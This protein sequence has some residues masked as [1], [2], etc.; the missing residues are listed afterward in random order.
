MTN[1]AVVPT[2]LALY[3]KHAKLYRA[4]IKEKGLTVSP[5][6]IKEEIKKRCDAEKL[7]SYLEKEVAPKDES[8]A[9][10]KKKAQPKKKVAEKKKAEPKKKPTAKKSPPKKKQPSFQSLGITSVRK[11]QLLMQPEVIS[12]LS[13]GFRFDLGSIQALQKNIE[14]VGEVYEPI[15]LQ[16]KESTLDIVKGKRRVE[17]IRRIVKKGGKLAPVPVMLVDEATSLKMGTSLYI[18]KPLNPL[19][20]A[21]VLYYNKEKVPANILATLTGLTNKLVKDRIA[22]VDACKSVKTALLKDE[23]TDEQ[24]ASIVRQHP[25]DLKAQNTAFVELVGR[26]VA[27]KV[28]EVPQPKKVLR[29]AL[30]VD[31]GLLSPT[32]ARNL[33]STIASAYTAFR[34]SE[35]SPS[36]SN[37]SWL[38][39]LDLLI[40]IRNL[41]ASGKIPIK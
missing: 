38:D 10:P 19:E 9:L 40:K 32:R 25:D 16:L 37:E 41:K 7:E 12:N 33:L 21:G 2:G 18:R 31:D 20:E 15:I 36:K 28:E 5:E 26:R 30:K 4:E 6:E 29:R 35:M 24:A 27:E 13:G 11:S 3:Q 1:K 39:L 17:A 22:L 14:F 8:K 23:L 34:R